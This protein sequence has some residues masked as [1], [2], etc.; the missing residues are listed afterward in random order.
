MAIPGS[1]T[2]SRLAFVALVLMATPA[3]VVAD[4]VPRP[5]P[6]ADRSGAAPSVEAPA[7]RA[8]WMIR[9]V[10]P[11][12]ATS[13]VGQH[14]VDLVARLARLDD[15]WILEAPA[16][17]ADRVRASWSTLGQLVDDVSG[18][19][20]LLE[21]TRLVGARDRVWGT[22]GL[23]GDITSSIALL[24]SGCDTA[25][26]DLGDPDLDNE[27]VPPAAGDER[28]W[29]DAALG[30][31]GDPQI[32]VI[33]WHDVTDDLP[34]AQGPWDY[35]F[36]GTAMAGAAMGGGEI[37][38][39]RQGVAPRGRL[40]VV[41]TWNY[42]DRWE[43]WASDLLLGMDWVVENAETYRIRA[44]LIG[45][46]WPVDL[47]FGPM[48]DALIERGVAVIAP[49][50]NGLAEVGYP[51]RLPGVI[52]VGATDDLGRVAAYSA[53]APGD[54]PV[55]GLDLVAPGGSHLDPE[56]GILTT[57][58]EPDDTYRA[59]IGTSIAAAH[60]AGAVSLVSQA[61]VE[62]GRSWRADADQVHWLAD[63]L[64]I[65][66]TETGGAEPGA[67][68]VPTRNRVGADRAEGHGLLQIPAAVDAVRRILWPGGSASFALAAPAE[69]AATWAARIPTPDDR[70]LEIELDVPAGADFDVLLYAEHADGFRLIADATSAREGGTEFLRVE[71]PRSAWSLVVARRVTGS[72]LAELRTRADLPGPGSWPASVRS[73]Q[74]SAPVVFDLDGDGRDEILA[75]NN[76]ENDATVHNFHA[77]NE[78]GSDF[79]FFPLTVFSS[80]R[81]GELTAPAVGVLDG[82][83][84]IVTGSAFGEVYAVRASSEL[85]WARTVSTGATTSPVLGR[86]AGADRVVLGI[87]TGL[88][89]LD[90]AGALVRVVPTSAAIT[91][92]PALGDVD[93]DG[94]DEIV[95]VD[96]SG[97]VHVVGFGGGARPGWPVNLG[98]ALTAPVLRGDGD[99]G[100]VREIVV[101]RRDA[102]GALEL[103]RLAPDASASPGS[104]LVLP[105]GGDAVITHSAPVVVPMQRGDAPSVVVGAVSGGLQSP[106]R[107]WCHVARSD[108]SVEARSQELTRSYVVDGFFLISDVMVAEPRVA[109]L[110]G[111]GEREVVVAARA[112]WTV[113]RSIEFVRTGGFVGYVVFG[114]TVPPELLP[115]SADRD[116][117]ASSGL[118]APTLADLDRD[119]RP[120]WIV[121][122]DREIQV[123]GTR[124]PEDLGTS[125]GIDR[126]SHDRRACVGCELVEP[127]AAPQAPVALALRA[128]PN[129]FNPRL[130][131]E[132]VLPRGGEVHWEMFDARGRRVRSFRTSASAAGSHRTTWDATDDQGAVLA[133][134]VYF[135][136]VAMDDERVV[137]RVTLVR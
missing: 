24:D 68:V 21:S 61:M 25:H 107:V 137:Q 42:E 109:D 65:T 113:L 63:L 106:V 57:D 14:G 36:H 103:H 82:E 119:G 98:G 123:T 71:R 45:V 26:D 81:P 75:V 17:S 89:I 58:N 29:A 59:R 51:A 116:R 134:G 4:L 56:G 111:T 46:V 108:G 41:K 83:L 43:R 28:D 16:D 114:S 129:P 62:S 13:L 136:A 87:P 10:D 133:S 3:E 22:Y 131:L 88:A 124:M 96:A 12:A 53:P 130:Q 117:I 47:G 74:R 54:R 31:S 50:G 34:L 95:A 69:G 18:S 85:R 93:G 39:R 70:A 84:A 112:T 97:R 38:D 92:A 110:H 78:D 55:D 125:W 64:R 7:T 66:T 132:A 19:P 27:D 127:V 79:S 5:L 8:R 23:R 2:L 35:H 99:G 48:I 30:L 9:P 49:A 104:P 52:A 33:G 126:G 11:D 76:A 128:V 100:P 73:V 105:T 91:Q 32:R 102:Q 115:L 67:L 120:E 94:Q 20:A 1:D 122:R 101:V 37:D 44:V 6:D 60:V 77:W 80:G 40:V 15:L 135:V 72:G 86:E 118:V 90:G 121:A